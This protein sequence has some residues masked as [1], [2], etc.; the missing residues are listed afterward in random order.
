MTELRAEFGDSRSVSLIRKAGKDFSGRLGMY[1][2]NL[3]TAE[4]LGL[5]PDAVFP[6]ASVIKIF[7]MAALY[8]EV[9][10]GRVDLESKLPLRDEDKT[11]GTGILRDLTAGLKSSIR[12][13]C[14][15]MIAL[16]D[17]T[18]T[19]MLVDHLDKERIN[20]II[21]SWGL[22]ATEL[23][24]EPRPRPDP[25]DYAVSTAREIGWMLE[26]IAKDTLLAAASGAAMRDHLAAQRDRSQLARRLPYVEFAKLVG[27]ENKLTV[28]NKTGTDEGIRTDAAIISGGEC[29]FLVASLTCDSDDFGFGLDHE[30][31][32]L[33]AAIGRILFDAWCST[34]RC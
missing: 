27:Q 6:T 13:L 28:M 7:I 2:K 29:S 31:S 1:A 4:E 10:T 26:Q 33:N 30:G 34:L 15:L 23:R 5:D 19:R 24:F 21:R 32:L 9:E 3:K 14:R 20:S 12:D 11:D 22:N 18:A 17:N 8:H 25:Q 16:S